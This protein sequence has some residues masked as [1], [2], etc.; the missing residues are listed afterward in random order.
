MAQLLIAQQGEFFLG[1]ALGSLALVGQTFLDQPGVS[2]AL[3][4]QRGQREGRDC[5]D[6]EN[7]KRH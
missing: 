7:E 6:D 3:V 4:D 2:A 1:S 5:D